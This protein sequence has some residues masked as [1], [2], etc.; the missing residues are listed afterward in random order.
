MLCIIINNYRCVCVSERERESVCVKLTG[1]CWGG[2]GI[3]CF[4]TNLETVAKQFFVLYPENVC[5]VPHKPRK[6]RL[7]VPEEWD[8]QACRALR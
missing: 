8:D 6:S 5:A 7:T 3:R 4:K 2:G 1:I